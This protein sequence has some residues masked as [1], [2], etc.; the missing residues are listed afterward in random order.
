MLTIHKNLMKMPQQVEHDQ[1][2][3]RQNITKKQRCLDL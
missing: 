3:K 1:T 2:A